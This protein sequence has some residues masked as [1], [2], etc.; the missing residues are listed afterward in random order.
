MLASTVPSAGIVPLVECV[1]HARGG[2][3]FWFGAEVD[4][5]LPPQLLPAQSGVA[6]D[7]PTNAIVETADG[8]IVNRGPRRDQAEFFTPGVHHFMFSITVPR[9]HELEWALL[10]PA[11]DSA[12]PFTV[13]T[14]DAPRCRGR[15]PRW[16]AQALTDGGVPDIIVGLGRSRSTGG[17]LVASSVV[18]DITRVR[19]ACSSGGR[20]LEPLV[21]WGFDDSVVMANSG[22]P[23][24]VPR[25]GY[26]PLP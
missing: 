10:I 19:S 17:R 16:A 25:N 4:P 15:A 6:P 2:D 1:E 21:L 26:S 8:V 20:P 3:T 22:L 14:K 7:D 23:D 11:D 13:A 18:F 24:E 12:V 9:G 5:L